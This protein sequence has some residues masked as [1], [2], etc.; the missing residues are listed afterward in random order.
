MTVLESCLSSSE[1]RPLRSP[2]SIRLRRRNRIKSSPPP[3]RGVR[4]T[5]RATHLF[6]FIFGGGG[7]WIMR[8]CPSLQTCPLAAHPPFIPA[9]HAIRDGLP[10]APRCELRSRTDFNGP[11][12]DYARRTLSFKVTPTLQITFSSRDGCRIQCSLPAKFPCEFRIGG[13]NDFGREGRL[14]A[15]GS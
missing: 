11:I 15:C 8:Q 12:N 9:S 6:L 14:F 3:P 5:R 4:N 1:L 10:A 13:A 7:G 2:S